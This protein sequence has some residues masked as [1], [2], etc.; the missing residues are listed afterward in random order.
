MIPEAR[1]SCCNTVKHWLRLGKMKRVRNTHHDISIPVDEPDEF[2]QAPEAALEAAE[3]K[4]G[5][6][7]LGHCQDKPGTLEHTAS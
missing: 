4:L 6:F 7:I 1:S 2:L 3:K 5:K